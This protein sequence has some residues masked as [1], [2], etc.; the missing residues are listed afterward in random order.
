MNAQEGEVESQFEKGV[1][2]IQ[3]DDSEGEEA[4]DNGQRQVFDTGGD[5]DGDQEDE[6]NG[7]SAAALGPLP[8]HAKETKTAEESGKENSSVVWQYFTKVGT[9]V[10][11]VRCVVCGATFADSSRASRRFNIGNTLRHIW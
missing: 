2:L 8:E 4:G 9:M 3:S 10:R 7:E 5:D 6:L 1:R 11:K